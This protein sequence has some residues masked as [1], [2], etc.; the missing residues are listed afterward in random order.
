MTDC[1][2]KGSPEINSKKI[3]G[4][5]E[6]HDDPENTGTSASKTEKMC[7]NFGMLHSYG[8]GYKLT[9]INL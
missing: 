5:V 3:Y 9:N 8:R 7:N 4:M 6:V 1:K 2:L